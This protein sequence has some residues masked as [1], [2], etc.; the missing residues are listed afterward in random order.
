MRFEWA[1]RM[2][3]ESWLFRKGGSMPEVRAGSFFRFFV[4]ESIFKRSRYFR[5]KCVRYLVTKS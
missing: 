4:E 3:G 5:Q 1:I 2:V